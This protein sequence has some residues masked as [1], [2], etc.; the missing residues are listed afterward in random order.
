[1]EQFYEMGK[2]HI[3]VYVLLT[4]VNEWGQLLSM[5]NQIIADGF[6][7]FGRF[8]RFLGQNLR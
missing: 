4:L 1:M 2:F 7:N 5:F 6:L 8:H 3:A